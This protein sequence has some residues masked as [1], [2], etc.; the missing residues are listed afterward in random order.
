[1]QIEKYVDYIIHN[2]IAANGYS[3]FNE[4][5]MRDSIREYLIAEHEQEMEKLAIKMDLDKKSG[6]KVDMLEYQRQYEV[7]KA[8]LVR[9]VDEL[10]MNKKY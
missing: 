7:I 9:R 2:F 10:A 4:E 6:V 8:N 3:E 5:R 1:M